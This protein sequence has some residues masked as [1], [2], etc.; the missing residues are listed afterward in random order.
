MHYDSSC[1]GCRL[2]QGQASKTGGVI[3]LPG[4]WLVNQYSGREGWLG[5]LALQPRFHRESLSD[6]TRD[7]LL[8]L[9]PNLKAI[10]RAL[11]LHWESRFSDDCL[12]RVYIVYFFESAFETPRPAEHYHLHIHLIA[13]PDSVAPAMR[14]S[15]GTS[16]WVDGWK[17]AS[18]AKAAAV[19]AR[20]SPTSPTWEVSV[21]ELMASLRSTLNAHGG[22]ANGANNAQSCIDDLWS[23]VYA[24]FKPHQQPTDP[25]PQAALNR[26]AA[27]CLKTAIVRSF[28]RANCGIHCELLTP[29]D[30][31]AL[32]TFHDK[33]TPGCLHE[34]IVVLSLGNRRVVIDGNKRV[35]KW[36]A[37]NSSDSRL[38]I[39]ISPGPQP[40]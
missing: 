32:T 15:E 17:A 40:A 20:Y 33:I 5:W 16:S 34:P 21:D 25:T 8:S 10:D 18:V 39:V 14:T 19:P 2:S 24:A 35:N 28:D 38:A 12:R 37:E 27:K 6:L 11:T 13:R 22:V 30:L 4:D 3:E 31:A 36:R 23:V 7:E 26:I 1:A 9:G 29:R